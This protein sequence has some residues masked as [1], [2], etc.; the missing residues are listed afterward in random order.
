MVLGLLCVSLGWEAIWGDEGSVYVG[1]VSHT[2]PLALGVDYVLK[3]E[4]YHNFIP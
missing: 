2:P 4:V 3:R 1:A